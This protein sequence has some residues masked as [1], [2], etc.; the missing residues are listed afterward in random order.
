MTALRH[1][2]RPGADDGWSAGGVLGSAGTREGYDLAT[3]KVQALVSPGGSAG[4]VDERV[5]GSL[6]VVPQD[7]LVHRGQPDLVDGVPHVVQP[8]VTH[9]RCHGEGMVPHAQPG[10]ATLL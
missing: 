8:A 6:E 9:V 10:V 2:S 4:G 7:R 1:H 3:G 5:S